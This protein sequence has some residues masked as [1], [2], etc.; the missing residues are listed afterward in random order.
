MG[1]TRRRTIHPLTPAATRVTAMAKR[2]VRAV[3]STVSRYISGSVL[4]I[5]A[6]ENHRPSNS[7]GGMPR[8]T[9]TNIS[10]SS[11]PPTSDCVKPSTRRLARSL[12]RTS[13]ATRALL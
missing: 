7:P 3:M 6:A 11:T 9:C 12:A 8:N 5:A 4:A 1:A 13:S 2:S 10:P